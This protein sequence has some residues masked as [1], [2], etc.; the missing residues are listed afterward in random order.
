MGACGKTPENNPTLLCLPWLSNG[1]VL[2]VHFFT[3][4]H[5]VALAIYSGFSLFIRQI[6]FSRILLFLLHLRS[7]RARSGRCLHPEKR[8]T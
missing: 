7:N 3:W 6:I 2:Q 8:R 5:Y 4:C 1:F